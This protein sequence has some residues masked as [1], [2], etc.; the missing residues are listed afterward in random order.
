MFLRRWVCE[1]VCERDI[2]D[3]EDVQQ[4]FGRPHG[5][6]DFILPLLVRVTRP[7]PKRIFPLGS[8]CL[9]NEGSL[10]SA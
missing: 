3:T 4:G 5:I 7:R 2:H 9:A 6:I 8:P 1:Q 10:P